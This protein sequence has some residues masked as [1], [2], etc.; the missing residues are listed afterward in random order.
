MEP[1]PRNQCPSRQKEEDMDLWGMLGVSRQVGLSLIGA[2][3]VLTVV[4]GL[5]LRRRTHGSNRTLVN[6]SGRG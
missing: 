4:F 1:A 3:V 6:L 2:A 5:V